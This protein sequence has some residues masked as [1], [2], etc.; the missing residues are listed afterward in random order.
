MIPRPLHQNKSEFPEKV[1]KFTFFSSKNEYLIAT[2]NCFVR[3][4]FF[5]FFYHG[6]LHRGWRF[7]GQQGKRRDHLLFHSTTPTHS[8]TLRHVFATLHVRW[9]S[10][11]FNRNAYVYQML[12]DEFFHLIELSFEWLIDDAMFVC[13][14]DEL[15]LGFCYIDLTLET[16]GFELAST[17]TLVLQANRLNQVR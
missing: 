9:L 5:F 10:R 4:F 6:F 1:S 15:I 8:R 7:S 13:L 3:S 12:P 16:G 17:I 11:I 14:L 2:T